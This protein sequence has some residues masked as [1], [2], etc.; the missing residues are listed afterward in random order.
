MKYGMLE[1][2][3]NHLDKDRKYSVGA[4][5]MKHEFMNTRLMI[6]YP[7]YKI[8]EG[9]KDFEYLIDG[10]EQ[11]KKLILSLGYRLPE[12]FFKFML[13]LTMGV[14]LNAP[15]AVNQGVKFYPILFSCTTGVTFTQYS[16]LMKELVSKSN[17]IIIC[18]EHLDL[19]E[20]KT[21]INR[22]PKEGQQP[23][24]Q[25]F[26]RYK[27]MRDNL[28]IRTND[29]KYFVNLRNLAQTF[30][31]LFEEEEFQHISFEKLAAMGH[32]LGGAATIQLSNESDIVNAIISL[33][34]FLQPFKKGIEGE[35][36][37][38]MQPHL[39]IVTET[40]MK[41]ETNKLL[42]DSLAE[43]RMKVKKMNGFQNVQISDMDMLGFS[44]QCMLFGLELSW[45]MKTEKS[46][47]NDKCVEKIKTTAKIIR[48]FLALVKFT[49]EPYEEHYEQLK[50]LKDVEYLLS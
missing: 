48:G 49:D 26:V 5:I 38:V 43:K 39:N 11:I 20:K 18:I 22:P 3:K 35:G 27:Y 24:Q 36:F 16:M 10:Q 9:F 17:L 30:R 25:S 8:V 15:L 31:I 12:A 46:N 47:D 21:R 28:L 33:T 19:K 23:D 37:M 40:F 44:D 34:P 32:G 41:N 29:L 14:K 13:D 6:Y 7:T 50:D 4:Q 45:L 1:K 2:F 42:I